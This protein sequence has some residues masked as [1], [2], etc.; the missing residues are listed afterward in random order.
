MTDVQQKYGLC[1]RYL[2]FQLNKLLPCWNSLHNFAVDCAWAVYRVALATYRRASCSACSRARGRRAC[3]WRAPSASPRR[4]SPPRG[5]WPRTLLAA[6][7]LLAGA[8]GWNTEN[9]IFKKTSLDRGRYCIKNDVTFK[10]WKTLLIWTQVIS[11]K[12][13]W[14]CTTESRGKKYL[15]G[16]RNERKNN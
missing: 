10:S 9:Q 3:A 6:D 2:I 8:D 14:F 11:Q 13:N 1:R 4:S 5:T 15:N 12:K 7:G 16:E